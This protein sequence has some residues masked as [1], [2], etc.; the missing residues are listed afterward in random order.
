MSHQ[1]LNLSQIKRC[2]L[3]KFLNLENGIIVATLAMIGVTSF[4]LFANFM[5]EYK[6]KDVEVIEPGTQFTFFIDFLKN[7][8]VREVGF[9]TN[10]D[11]SEEKNDGVFLQAQYMLAPIVLNLNEVNPEFNI[12]DYTDPVWAI[13]TI[14]S[15][16][17]R[18]LATSPYGQILAVKRK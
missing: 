15:L 13:Y 2:M 3:K 1:Y 4:Y 11:M 6:K 8:D 12:M 9:L 18:P 10:K 7:A 17:A 16:R 5:V 14:K